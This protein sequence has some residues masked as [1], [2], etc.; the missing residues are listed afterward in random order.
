MVGDLDHGCCCWWLQECLLE[1]DLLEEELVGLMRRQLVLLL[2]RQEVCCG[3]G[4]AWVGDEVLDELSSGCGGWRRQ[5]EGVGSIRSEVA[6]V[7]GDT[8]LCRPVSDW[9]ERLL[10]TILASAAGTSEAEGQR[11]IE[12][13]LPPAALQSRVVRHGG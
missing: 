13:F 12:L 9:G 10:V 2:N 8:L 1:L 5:V 11:L 3:N 4:L 6:C 7:I